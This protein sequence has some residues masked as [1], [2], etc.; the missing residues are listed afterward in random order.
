MDTTHDILLQYYEAVKPLI[1]LWIAVEAGLTAL[2]AIGLTII[3]CT[4]PKIFKTFV[5]WRRERAK[6]SS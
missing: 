4:A 1:V 3:V 2:K 5:D 6:V